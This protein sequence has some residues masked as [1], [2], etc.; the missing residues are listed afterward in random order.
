M[1][2]EKVL[3]QNIMEEFFQANIG[4]IPAAKKFISLKIFPHDPVFI[5]DKKVNLAEYKLA[6]LDSYGEEK[7]ISLRGSADNSNKRLKHYHVL[8]SLR[9]N[10]FDVG[11]NIVAEPIGY[12]K[13]FGLL[14]YKNVS[15]QSLYD[16]FKWTNKEEWTK[17]IWEAIDWL[18]DFHAKKPF[19]I[20][21]AK[22]NWDEERQKFY[23]LKKGLL[24]RYPLSKALIE[25]V[26]KRMVE[27]EN[28]LLDPKKFHL[29]HGDY[30]P[31]NILF[32]DYPPHTIA[33]DFNDSM[34][35]DELYDI[36]Y[37]VAQIRIMLK[38]L[39]NVDERGLGDKII[40]YYLI[41][42]N[43]KPSANVSNKISLFR[44]KTLMHIKA[45]T[46]EKRVRDILPDLEAYAIKAI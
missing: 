25:Q 38:I 10:G 8:K 19:N 31:H 15:G 40:E 2:T 9:S 45:V 12:Y 41:K 16:K 39:H 33:I 37:F 27:D 26:T 46:E 23:K 35:Y 36:S 32:S 4:S 5:L 28:R 24:I 30:Q 29:V 43:I 11:Q 44:L 1:G 3:D 17:K 14:L 7:S 22:F 13:D 6:Y 18:V 34:F 42:R 21:E 20:P